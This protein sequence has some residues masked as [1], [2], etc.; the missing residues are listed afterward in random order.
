MAMLNNQ[1]VTDSLLDTQSWFTAMMI[2]HD[3]VGS[4]DQFTWYTT[5]K[6]MS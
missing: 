2:Y 3:T 4:G 5:V 1:R 6:E